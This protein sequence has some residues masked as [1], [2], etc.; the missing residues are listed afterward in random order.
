M[1]TVIALYFIVSSQLNGG[2]NTFLGKD[3]KVVLSGS[4]SPTFETGSLVAVTPKTF[5]QIRQNDILTFRFEND[6][7]VT[8]RVIE[9][10]PDRL[11][12][13]GDANDAADTSP[14]LPEQVIGTVEYWIPYFGYFVN[15]V[16]SPL[17]ML[18]MLGIPGLYLIISS[19]WSL[20]KT[21]NKLEQDKKSTATPT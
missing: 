5:D 18:L 1:I 10:F 8:H 17:G 14:I 20:L 16:R 11:I 9:V 3:L 4:M 12:T 7:I 6:K 15:F 13:K 19:M 2:K 21:L